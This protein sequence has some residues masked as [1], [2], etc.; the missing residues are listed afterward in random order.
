MTWAPTPEPE[1]PGPPPPPDHD[2]VGGWGPR[3]SPGHLGPAEAA[4]AA[5]RSGARHVLPIHYGTLHPSGWPTSRLAWT[6]DPGH[7]F[8]DDLRAVSDA[9]AHVPAVGGAVTIRAPR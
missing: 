2:P 6:T 3:L 8:T 7:R 5:V 9:V 4:E 1:V